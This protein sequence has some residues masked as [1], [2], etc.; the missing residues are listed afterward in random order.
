MS[1]RA[2]MV[3]E[4]LRK[5][6]REIDPFDMATWDYGEFVAHAIDALPGAPIEDAFTLA[7]KWWLERHPEDASA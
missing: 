4:I 3:T 5:E 6:P 1:G 2:S 7:T